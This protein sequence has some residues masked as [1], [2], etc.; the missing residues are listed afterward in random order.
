MWTNDYL[1]DHFRAVE[2]LPDFWH[3]MRS[4]FNL[5]DPEY[6]KCEARLLKEL[7][8]VNR[9]E[10]T[11]P[12]VKF[13]SRGGFG[14]LGHA[15]QQG[16]FPRLKALQISDNALSVDEV[17]ELARAIKLGNLSNLRTF[18]LTKCSIN[19]AGAEVLAEAMERGKLARLQT[20]EM[21]GNPIGHRGLMALATLLESGRLPAL[22]SLAVSFLG[23]TQPHS[24]VPEPISTDAADVFGRALQSEQMAGLKDLTLRHIVKKELMAAVSRAL[25]LGKNAKLRSFTLSDCDLG[26]AEAKVVAGVFLSPNFS[27]LV[28]LNLGDN[29]WVGDD[30]R[31]VRALIQGFKSP[32]LR[33]L[34]VLNMQSMPS[35]SIEDEHLAEIAALLEVGHL[36]GLKTLHARNVSHYILA[37]LSPPAMIRAYQNNP[38]LVAEVIMDWPSQAMQATAEGL[39]KSNQKLGKRLKWLRIE[40]QVCRSHVK[41]FLCGHA[42]VGKTTLRRAL[43]R[44]QW[45]ALRTSQSDWRNEGPAKDDEVSQI[46]QKK[47]VLRLW[48][49]ELP[50]IPLADGPPTIFIIVCS[51]N[52]YGS[53]LEN[54]SQAK[55]QLLHWMNYISS[56]SVEGHH[57]GRRHVIVVLNSF[58]GDHS[59]HSEPDWTSFITLY[60]EIYEDTLRICHTPF[61]L[62]ALS[63]KEVMRFKKK[64][65]DFARFRTWNWTS[66]ANKLDKVPSRES[67]A[68]LTGPGKEEPADFDLWRPMTP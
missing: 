63:R 37:V 16:C 40:P 20:L 27:S 6:E 47:H 9:I 35:R 67:L 58:E 26:E 22:K 30:G 38:F 34:Q 29:N 7:K 2:A 21:D 12:S 1:S 13:P 64:L 49:P 41:V 14:T 54:K 57:E 31:A 59:C 4:M 51:A 61:I 42:R 18:S 3:I 62:N 8:Q 23:E 32:H 68:T 55:Q 10:L 25:E 43:C 44:T 50:Q 65:L 33:T 39:R 36:P 56:T 19:A 28:S 17:K 5:T 66:Q 15:L 24:R 11:I 52:Y 46:V 45:E 53:A 48:D 60:S